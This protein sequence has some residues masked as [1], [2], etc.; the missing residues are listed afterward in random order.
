MLPRIRVKGATIV[1]MDPTLGIIEA[2]D[3]LIDEGKIIAIGRNVGS[4][5]VIEIDGRGM[6]AMPGFINGHI[7]LWQTA[8]RGVAAD[9]TLDHYFGVLIGRVVGLYSPQDVYIGNLV[10][11]LDQINSG[12]TTLFDWCHIVN[13]PAHADAAVDALRDARIRALFAYGTP[14]TLF[15]TKE[16]HPADA[17]RMRKERLSSGDAL[18]TMALAIRGTDFAPGTAEAD[19]RFARELGLLASF[20]VACAKHGP[21]PQSMQSLAEQRLLGPDVNLVHA[22]FLSPEEFRAIANNGASVSITPEVEM[23]MG[24]GL[25]PTGAVLA[26]RA[27]MN[28]GTDVVTGVSTDMFTQM[29]FLIQTQRALTNDT[30]HKREAMPDKLVMTARQAL[31]LATIKSAQ[32]FGLDGRIGSLTPGKE[33]DVVLL[34]KTDINMRAA[35]DPISAIVLHAGVANVDTVIVGGDIVKQNGKLT[36]RDLP[37]RLAELERSSKRLYEGFA[38]DVSAA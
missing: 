12:V 4:W 21:R 37:Q 38:T 27:N 30:F 5:A 3:L 6:I 24:L 34:R 15:G 17:A 7:H 20:H 35:A 31:E 28:I 9:W 16:P 14:M 18:V 1:S 29:R 19:I 26:A 25:P 32:C 13:T 36:H 10:G 33:A 2:G 22:N 8:L 23:Q 11:A